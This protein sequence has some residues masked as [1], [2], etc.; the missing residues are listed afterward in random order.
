ML[1]SLADGMMD[2]AVNLRYELVNRPAELRW[3]EWIAAQ[4]ARI[5]AGLDH[6]SGRIAQLAAPHIGTIAVAAAP[7]PH[8][9]GPWGAI[10]WRTTCNGSS[11]DGPPGQTR[12]QQ[13]AQRL[14]RYLRRHFR[15]QVIPALH[16]AGRGTRRASAA[17][18][19]RDREVFQHSPWVGW[20]R[21]WRK[22]LHA[23]NC[24]PRQKPKP[25]HAFCSVQ[26]RVVRSWDGRSPIRSRSA[27]PSMKSFRQPVDE[28]HGRSVSSL[29]G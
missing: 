15:R 13:P 20:R 21:L 25:P 28:Q 22:E 6:L 7:R 16:G 27:L 8:E 23:R 10:S 17:H 3:P 18:A 2:A 4:R 14:R 9:G 29:A 12:G 19:H 11:L 1:E 24:L 26:S 5:D